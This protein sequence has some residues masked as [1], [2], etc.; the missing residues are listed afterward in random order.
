MGMSS[1]NC[2]ETLE[3]IEYHIKEA[4]L[5]FESLRSDVDILS[6]LNTELN[7]TNS[8]LEA[9]LNEPFDSD[10][11]SILNTI[12]LFYRREPTPDEL[13]ELRDAY[14]VYMARECNIVA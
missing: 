4:P 13:D 8:Q 3:T 7:D 11:D 14:R 1:D 10:L 9:E 12:G 5:A 6:E 2:S